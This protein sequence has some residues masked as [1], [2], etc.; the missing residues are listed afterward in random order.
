MLLSDGQSPIESKDMN[1]NPSIAKKLD[2][3]SRP[4]YR[5]LAAVSA[6]QSPSGSLPRVR[7]SPSP[8]AW[9]KTKAGGV[10]V[11]SKMEANGPGINRESTGHLVAREQQAAVAHR[12]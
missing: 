12:P 1:R 6:Q 2:W 7:R 8:T 9:Q 4:G 10:A 11:V 3:Q 5:W